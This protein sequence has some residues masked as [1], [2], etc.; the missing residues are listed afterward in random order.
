MGSL[1][2]SD[3]LGFSER[4]VPLA[5]FAFNLMVKKS[6]AKPFSL[7]PFHCLSLA[8]VHR[9][10]REHLIPGRTLQQLNVV[11]ISNSHGS[12][13]LVGTKKVALADSSRRGIIG[14]IGA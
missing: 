1:T 4:I 14:R 8:P 9:S 6:K 13:F 3:S 2:L 11:L 12:E 10:L 7:V 5:V